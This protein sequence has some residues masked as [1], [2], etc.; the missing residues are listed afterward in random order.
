[1]RN[2]DSTWMNADCY[3]R[4]PCMIC[5]N[6]AETC[7]KPT[8]PLK[9]MLLVGARWYCVDHGNEMLDWLEQHEKEQRT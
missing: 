1:M 7:P 3:G 6:G 9:E 2:R 8:A 5:T 4:A